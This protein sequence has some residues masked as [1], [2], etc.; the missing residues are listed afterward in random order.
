MD[1]YTSEW[2][3]T[4]LVLSFT[5]LNQRNA[6]ALNVS[7]GVVC[8]DELACSYNSDVVRVTDVVAVNPSIS[9]SNETLLSNV[10]DITIRGRGFVSDAYV[11]YVRS[12]DICERIHVFLENPYISTR[13]KLF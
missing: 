4:H 13:L 8:D 3:F 7:V 1:G 6:G 11:F 10:G 5:R 12:R 9:L 2:S